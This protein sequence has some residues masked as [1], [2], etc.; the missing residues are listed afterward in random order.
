[1]RSVKVF[2][3]AT[4]A[5]VACGFDIL[6]FAVDSPGDEVRVTL[7]DGEGVKI[8]KIEGDNGKLSLDPSN[9]TAG[10]SVLEF[11]K[12]LNSKQGVEI[13]LYK[14]LPFGSG[15]GSSAASAVASVFALN[16]L[17]QRPFTVEQ[18]VPFTMESERIA[19]GTAHADNVAPGL[20]GGFVLIRSYEPLD[21]V[22]IPCPENLYCAL[23]HPHVEVKTEDARKIL[24]RDIQLKDAIVQWGNIAGLI[25]GLMQSNFPLIGRSL[26]DV[27]VEPVRSMLIPAFDQ[28]KEA[29]MNAGALGFSISGSGPT[30]FALSDSKEKADQICIAIAKVFADLKLNSDQYVSAINKTGPRIID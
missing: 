22:R 10:V 8:T 20:L 1:M 12:K 6:G 5:N 2:A 25:A 28:A 15:L 30:V 18:L 14:K 4:V 21:I 9:N 11:L 26:T 3:P 24:R 7:T 17:M 27:I 19:C 29:A 16:E 13:E 23:V